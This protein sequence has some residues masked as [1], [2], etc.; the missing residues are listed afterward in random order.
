MALAALIAALPSAPPRAYATHM[1]STMHSAVTSACKSQC[2]VHNPSFYYHKPGRLPPNKQAVYLLAEHGAPVCGATSPWHEL[3][4]RRTV[5]DDRH[6]A[7][8]E[9]GRPAGGLLPL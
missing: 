1:N 8:G 5:A 3:V 2:T 4:P 9:R 6:G 7:V